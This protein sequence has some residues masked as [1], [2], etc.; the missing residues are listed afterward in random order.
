M[1]QENKRIQ[2]IME[3]KIKKVHTLLDLVISAVVL[4]AGVGVYFILPGW[5]ILFGL[6]GILLFAFY[7]RSYRRVGNRTSLKQKDR[8]LALEGRDDVMAYLQG[9]SDE[10]SLSPAG[11]GDHLWLDVYYNAESAVAYVQLYDVAEN[12]FDPATQ[13]V[14]LKGDKARKLIAQL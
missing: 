6:I 8:D 1:M 7:K 5:G 3:I 4:A 9:K 11:E 10:L 13:L 2:R 12:R 14:E